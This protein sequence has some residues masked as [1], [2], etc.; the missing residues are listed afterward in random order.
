MRYENFL[1]IS[2]FQIVHGVAYTYNAYS[3]TV[4]F[5]AFTDSNKDLLTCGKC[6]TSSML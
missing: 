6:N 5:Q 4:P 3:Y 2:L 1:H